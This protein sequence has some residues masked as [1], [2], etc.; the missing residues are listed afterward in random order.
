MY[1]SDHDTSASYTHTGQQSRQLRAS[2]QAVPETHKT[3]QAIAA[4]QA[5]LLRHLQELEVIS[6]YSQA[7]AWA[8]L[9]IDAEEIIPAGRCNWL[10]FVWL[11]Q[12]QD[13][14]RRV[15]EFIRERSQL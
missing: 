4:D 5:N 7:H 12:Q 6:D 10:H 8:A 9:V 1:P 15:S 2:T 11:S 14:Q 13:Q 3:V